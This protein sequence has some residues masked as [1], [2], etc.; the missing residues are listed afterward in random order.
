MPNRARW[1]VAKASRVSAA[2]RLDHEGAEVLAGNPSHDHVAAGSHI[3]ARLRG[4][5]EI[6]SH[7]RV[8]SDR[9]E[10]PG[11][12]VVAERSRLITP[13][14]T[15]STYPD[16]GRCRV[17]GLISLPRLS[18]LYCAAMTRLHASVS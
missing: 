4:G 16:S 18:D 8:E 9:I 3:H 13:A 7:A 11:T 14:G 10:R 15:Q 12:A 6:G 5:Q 17:G 1:P 2:L